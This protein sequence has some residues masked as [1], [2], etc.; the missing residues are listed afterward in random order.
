M[1]SSLRAIRHSSSAWAGFE[2][3][4]AV[5]LTVA[6]TKLCIQIVRPALVG[7][8]TAQFEA[9]QVPFIAV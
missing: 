5:K 2:P 3:K 1:M 4:L 7:D 8:P 6:K 9:L